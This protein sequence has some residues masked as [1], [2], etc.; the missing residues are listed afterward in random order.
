MVPLRHTDSSALHNTT[1]C[2]SEREP[3]PTPHLWKPGAHSVH[4]TR[5]VQ[6]TCCSLH[7]L[8][9]ASFDN[10]KL[11]LCQ[12]TKVSA[13]MCVCVCVM[14]IFVCVCGC[15]WVFG[16]YAKTLILFCFFAWLLQLTFFLIEISFLL[17][18]SWNSYKFF[19]YHFKGW[20]ILQTVDQ[21]WK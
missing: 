4:V 17:K 18:C 21:S 7:G 11:S 8:G 10:D 15:V 2:R 19:N 3:V 16:N 5:W 20:Q 14:F 1:S 9:R 12:K 13:Y 6:R